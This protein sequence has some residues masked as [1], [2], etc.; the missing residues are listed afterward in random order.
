M[1]WHLHLWLLHYWNLQIK[2][3]QGSSLRFILRKVLKLLGH[4]LL[5]CSLVGPRFRFLITFTQS[6]NIS[7][8]V[9]IKEIVFHSMSCDVLTSF[10]NKLWV[11]LFSHLPNLYRVGRDFIPN[12]SVLGILMLIGNERYVKMLDSK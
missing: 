8:M 6:P 9:F 12:V 3:L 7:E 11:S 5:G 4:C 10:E 2:Q 1:Q